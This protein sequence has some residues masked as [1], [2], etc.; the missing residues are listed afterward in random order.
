MLIPSKLVGKVVNVEKDMLQI[1]DARYLSE[2]DVV[3]N[4]FTFYRLSVDGR[5]NYTLK[6]MMKT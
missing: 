3:H 1:H 5:I 6:D 2:E 4:K